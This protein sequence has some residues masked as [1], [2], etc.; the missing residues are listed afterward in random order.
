[1]ALVNSLNFLPEVFRTTT[2]QRFAG[3]TVDQLVQDGVVAPLSGYVGRTF[4]P[5]YKLGDNYVPET[6]SLRKNY[7]LESSVVIQDDN[8]NVLFTAGYIDLLK[9]IESNNGFVNNHQRLFSEESYSYDGKFDYDKFVNYGNYYWLPNGPDAVSIYSNQVPLEASFAVTRN[10]AVNGYTFSGLGGHP[11]PQ[12]ILARGGTYEFTL[13]QPGSNF[14]IQYRPGQAGIEPAIPTVSTRDVYGVTNNGAET[15]TIKFKVPQKSAQNFFLEMKIVEQVDA[16]VHFDYTE[17]QNCRLSDFLKIY[18]AGL[19]GVNVAQGKTFVFIGNKI[20]DLN[21]TNPAYPTGYQP[22]TAGGIAVP[23]KVIS[24][25]SR[26][27]VWQVSLT[28]INNGT[29][30][31]IQILPTT[32]V[33]KQQKVFIV[34]GKTEASHEY[35]VD[36]NYRFNRVPLITANADYLYYQD[37]NNP[38]FFGEIKLVDATGT[39]INVVK[40]ILGKKGYTSPNGII[41]T[42][43][44]KVKFDQTTLPSIYASNE[45]Y[46][47]GVGT[48]IKL[49]PTSQCIVP[50]DFGSHIVDTADYI[51]INRASQDANP[52]SR[53][54]RWFHKDVLY[55]TSLYNNTELSYGPNIPARRPIIEFEA[56]LQLFNYGRQHKD[57]V[58]LITFAESD[59]FNEV[60]GQRS[61][62]VDGVT[63]KA[64]DRLIFANDYDNAVK[65]KIWQVVVETINNTKFIRLIETADD[66]VLANENVLITQGSYVGN[67]YRFDG[68]AWH[69]CQAKE[70]FN[71]TPMFDLVDADGY[72]FADT[73]VYP[74]STFGTT[75]NNLGT[76]IGGTRVFGYYNGNGTNDTILGFPLKYQNFNNIGDIVF[77]NYFDTETFTTSVNSIVETHNCNTGYLVKNSGLNNQAKLNTW[78]KNVEP[79]KQYQI[80]TKFF[81]GYVIRDD[82]G[83]ERA[84][85]QIDVTPI[86]ETTVPYVKVYLNNSLLQKNI[87]YVVTKYGVYDV[88][89]LLA[90][91]SIGDKI[92]VAVFS[93]TASE[94]GYYE[95]PQN[96]DLNPLNENFSTI[97][98]GQ[99]RNHYNKLIENTSVDSSSGTIPVQDK[100]LKAQGG[101]LIQHSS[102]LPYA[103][104]FLNDPSASFIDSITLA[105][106]EYSRFKNKFISLCTT[107]PGI[108]YNN[109]ESGVDAIMQNINLVKNDSF[110]WYY[111]DMVPQGGNYSTVTYKVLNVRQKQ[112]EIS[113]LF[114]NTVLSNRAVLVYRNNQQL[115]LGK[116]YVF[117]TISPALIF[118]ITLEFDDTIVIKDYFNTDGCY[119]PETPTKLG[120]YPKFEPEIYLDTGYQT[121]I[122]VIRGHDGSLTP[123]FGDFRDQFLLELERRIFNNI[124]TDYLSNSIN[125]YDTIPGYFRTTDYTRTEFDRILSQNFL[126]WVGSNKI[127]YT[128]NTWYDANNS[129][130][131]NYGGLADTV[132]GLPLQGS[133]RAIYNYWFDTDSPHLRPWEMLGFSRQPSWWTDRYGAAPYTGSNLTLWEDLAN[134]YIWNN[135]NPYT[136]VRFARPNLTNIIPVDNIGNLK[137]PAEIPLISGYTGRSASSSFSVGQQGPVE[138][139]WRHSSDYAYALQVAIALSRPAKYF[140]TQ[141][142]TSR[143]YTNPVTGYFTNSENQKVSPTLLKVN[144][145]KS[146][147]TTQRTS[148]YINWIFDYVKNLGID[149]V[150]KFTQYFKH[151]NM[152]LGYKIGGFTDKKIVTVSAEQT[153]PSSTNASVIIPDANYKIHLN[154]SVPVK[155]VSYSAVIIENVEAGYSVTGYDTANPYFTIH[156]SIANNSASDSVTINDI[157]VK[158]YKDSEKEPIVIP[159]GTTFTSAQQVADFLISYERYLVSQGFSFSTFDFDLEEVRNWQLSVKEFLYWAQQGWDVGTILLLNP[160]ADTV[161]INS[162]Q[163]VLDEITNQPAGSRLLD[164][165]YQTIKNTHFNILRKENF[166]AGNQATITTVGGL[167]MCY[168]KFN[169]VQHE[170]ILLLDNVSDFGDIIYVPSLGSRQYRLKLT[171]SKTGAWTG[172]LDAPGF[173]YSS[174]TTEPWVPGKDYKIGDIVEH[175]NQYYI[176]KSNLDA[177]ETFVKSQWT[178]IKEQDIQS[179]LL[180]SFGQNALEFERIYNIDQ[181]PI[182]ENLQIFS[183]GLIGFR[184]RPYLT[185]L[186]MSISNQTKFYQGFIKQKGTINSISALTKASFD[187]VGGSVNSYEEWAFRVGQYGD[188]D[189][190]Q[191]SEFILDQSV[192]TTNP[193]AFTVTT[194]S[195]STANIIVNLKI[196]ANLQLSNV[197]NSSNLSTVSTTL[198]NNRTDTVYTKDLP[199]AGYVNLNDI[200]ATIFDLTTVTTAPDVTVGN[201][202]WVAK[203]NNKTWN[204]FRVNTTGVVATTL[205]YIL[206]NYA[207]LT[208]NSA[209]S[210]T[211]G[212][213]IILKD[214]NIDINPKSDTYMQSIFDGMYKVVSVNGSNSI[215]ITI[216]DVDNLVKLIPTPIIGNGTV[217][218]LASVKVDSL[219][220]ANSIAPIGGWTSSDKIW[221]NNATGNQ[222][223]VYAYN[224]SNSSWNLIRQQ[225]SKV[226]ISSVN[227]TFLY[228]KVNN[229]IV[230]ALDFIDPNKGKILNSIERDIDYNRTED[231]ALY[232]AGNVILNPTLTITSDYHWGA[233]EVGKIWWDLDKVRYVD[234]E[235]DALIYRLNHWGNQFPGSEI[236]VY[237]WVESLVPPSQYAGP[238][239]PLHSDDSAYSTSGYVDQIGGVKLKYY[240]WVTNKDTINT[241]AGKYNSIASITAAIE[242]PA[243][244]G[245]PFAAILRNDTVALYNVNR[246]LVGKNVVLHLGSFSPDADLVHTQYALVQEGNA[247]SRV[248]ESILVKFIDSLSGVD[249][250]GNAVPDPELTP[251]QAYGISIRP[252]QSMFMDRSLALKNYINLVNIDLLKYPVTQRKVL[253][254][255]NSQENIPNI[256]S[257]EYDL[258][259]NTIDELYYLNALDLTVGTTKVLV[260]VDSTQLNKWSIY[261]LTG[262]T[263]SVGEFTLSRTQ[264]YKTNL[265]W[266]Y[267]DWYDSSYNST[268]TPDVTVNTQIDFG[269]LTLVAG[270]IIKI[271]DG[272]DG[273]FA[274]YRVNSDL[275]T[276]LVG[277]ESGTIQIPSIDIPTKELRQITSA[278]QK[279]IFVEDLSTEYTRIFFSMIKFILSEQKN[280]D[281]VFKTSFISASQN[282]RKLQEYPAYVKDN[283]DYYLDYIN[284]VKPYRTILREYVVNYSRNDPY[285]GDITDFDVPAYWDK[286]LQIYRAPNGDQAS[287]SD[288]LASDGYRNWLNNHTYKVVDVTIEDPGS[289]YTLPPQLTVTGGGGSGANLYAT[290]NSIGQINHIYVDNPGSGYT[291]TP[292]IIINGIGSGARAKAILRNAYSGN[293][294]GHNLI[295]SIKT[296]I[297]FDRTTYT[298][299]NTFVFWGEVTSNAAAYIGKTIPANTVVVL[300]SQLFSLANDYV[301]TGN[302]TTNIA[303]FPTGQVTEISAQNFNTANDRIIAFN[304]NVDLISAVGGLDYPGVKIEGNTYLG[305]NIDTIIQS[306]YSDNLGID[307]ANVNIDGGSYVDSY[308]SHAPEELVPG[309]MYDSFNLSVYQTDNIG[310]RY[311]DNMLGQRSYFRIADKNTTRL[312][313]NL[314]LTD[315]SIKV[316]DATRLQLPNKVTGNP[317]IIFINGEKITYWRNYALEAHIPWRSNIEVNIDTLISYNGN[318]YLNNGNVYAANFGNIAGN[319]TLVDPNTLTQLRRG[320][321]GT[322]VAAQHLA[323]SRVIDSSLPQAI[324][325][326]T[327]SSSVLTQNKAYQI[328]SVVAYGIRTTS[329]IN[330]NVGDVITTLTTVDEWRPG[331]IQQLGSLLYFGGTS[332]TTTGNVYGQPTIP[333]HPNTTYPLNTYISNSN[334]DTFITKGN[335]YTSFFDN[336]TNRTITAIADEDIAT[337]KFGNLLATGNITYAFDGNST[338]GVTLRA[339]E[340]VTDQK[341]FGA[342]IVS[343]DIIGTQGKP[344][345]YDSEDG[346]D[347]NSFSTTSSKLLING[348]QSDSYIINS[349]ILGNVTV[350]GKTTVPASS[351]ISTGRIWYNLGPAGTLTDGTGL[352]NSTTPQVK[353]LKNAPSF[354]IS[355]GETP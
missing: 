324:P 81:E 162:T 186:G 13:N 221:V 189:R 240:F 348:E 33:D 235:Q 322:G 354:T 213:Y 321:D 153:S 141:I 182:D 349:Y 299:S 53:S 343:G 105:R 216:S 147:G 228:N 201:R 169:L 318:V 119:V 113:G 277:I 93:N 70:N 60:E 132:N 219:S 297:K 61:A 208:F 302:A 303:N 308:S 176:S 164:Q 294:I 152:K 353:F 54:N 106:K 20:D 339:L 331:A 315:T 180:P 215:R 326:T 352:I 170:H 267:A 97:T 275:S 88:V 284:E 69:L 345:F 256:N 192:F 24:K 274:M 262:R 49:I 89:N 288:L 35:W 32:V 259:V 317:G 48:S 198:Y 154:K 333:W 260:K 172:A 62:I 263:D 139:A 130:T 160:A 90:M 38:D 11:N 200:D 298:N 125:L 150:D 206:D 306:R 323:G 159:Y 99:I 320:V 116:D 19:D 287:D 217:Y 210:L 95:I 79:N 127:D 110:P 346:F 214:F 56:D 122:N 226:D 140:G 229:N 177:T 203:D 67:T 232:N 332:Y 241:S 296:N 234:Y 293:N 84:F 34:S 248:P 85:V 17:I 111:S 224:K 142:D 87:D 146:S 347:V 285:F 55:T 300:N 223:G 123:A 183:S 6:T 92:D 227:R 36:N 165:N 193:V 144:G 66:P 63:V 156:P 101:K 96:L 64:G 29:D 271:I 249:A 163:L 46:I 254:T 78:V 278:L 43:G 112:Y 175:T 7:Q 137:S 212:D 171:G 314:A 157:T 57:N 270:Q 304:G 15:G 59:A 230:A 342:I 94:T 286:N 173:I 98:L 45:F 292:D 272:G 211:A 316:V 265:Y 104:S 9:T 202:I 181:P 5:T 65:G 174:F 72:S 108:D 350:D 82:Q 252:R 341:T 261:T 242:N 22:S 244:Q 77:T 109:P 334:G 312:S 295:R 25:E 237:E 166:I 179:G 75:R 279:E 10:T 115:V 190:N 247:D 196:D 102:P 207:Q 243:S 307:A 51:T 239:I 305:T 187:N 58:N 80:F 225:Q 255:L 178:Q 12:L 120:L 40:D 136:D 118:L 355:S 337:F 145:D 129:W 283:Q 291:T 250:A 289:G 8:K 209:H 76:Q 191:Y 42:N 134:G 310:W 325:A 253:T 351:T 276:S 340:S 151:L 258:T 218:K 344:E 246:L 83:V 28:S 100:Y 68:S 86:N 121:P 133:W 319:L 188:L 74:N 290:I 44:L 238:G 2:N 185:D 266:D 71:Q 194:D 26:T 236:K 30:Y 330:V 199:T 158:V 126:Q 309:R 143:F 1:M 313:A 167:P 73:T 327:V 204:V 114:D 222:W 23:G 245:V 328:T 124:K 336:L 251:A 91:P 39:A 220:T 268:S 311:F 128:S 273:K 231:P 257:R 37:I 161:T 269:K 138:T 4:S 135:G 338:V 197:Y 195:Y 301:I 155:S 18:P 329:N 16:A 47:E 264:F 168:G 41:F 14:W 117:S 21:W 31:L 27:S 3:A 282:I 149:P 335:V 205:T 131:W 103:I 148:G 52:W 281:W 107:L 280:L 50:E 184:Q 233:A